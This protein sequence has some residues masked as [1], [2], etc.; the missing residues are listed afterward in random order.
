MPK[1]NEYIS[2]SFTLA[3]YPLDNIFPCGRPLTSNFISLS[4]KDD[5]D[6]QWYKGNFANYPS[7]II[8][9]VQNP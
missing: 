6:G 9:F 1:I 4:V 5:K 7:N 8:Y 2:Y 3:E